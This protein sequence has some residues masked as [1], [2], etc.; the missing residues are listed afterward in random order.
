MLLKR[1]MPS[2]NGHCF[3]ET[4]QCSKTEVE[5]GYWVGIAGEWLSGISADYFLSPGETLEDSED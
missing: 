2:F 5:N 4:N 1:A 3:L